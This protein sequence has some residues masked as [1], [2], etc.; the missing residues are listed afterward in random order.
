MHNLKLISVNV[1]PTTIMAARQIHF[2][3]CVIMYKFIEMYL[4][5]ICLLTCDFFGVLTY[6]S[7]YNSQFVGV[8]IKAFGKWKT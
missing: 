7:P 4:I 2:D 6:A 8:G 5:E 3:D 1:A